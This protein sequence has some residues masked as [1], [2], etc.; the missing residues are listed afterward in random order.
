MAENAALIREHVYVT[1]PD[2]FSFLSTEKTDL[3][4]VTVSRSRTKLT[5]NIFDSI[6]E[7]NRFEIK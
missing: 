1:Q 3:Q 2:E 6:C 4:G 7:V 5:I